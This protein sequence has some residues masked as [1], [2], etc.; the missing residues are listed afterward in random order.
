MTVQQRIAAICTSLSR[1]DI[2]RPLLAAGPA[3]DSRNCDRPVISTS[4]FPSSPP[5]GAT[6]SVATSNVNRPLYDNVYKYE[7]DLHKNDKWKIL[8][9]KST[10]QL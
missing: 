7:Q 10:K 9:L 8:R 2:P 3:Y 6:A 1:M 4:G 5:G